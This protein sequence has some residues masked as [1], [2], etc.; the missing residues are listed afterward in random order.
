M[1]YE[2]KPSL[3]EISFDAHQNIVTQYEERAKSVGLHPDVRS[4]LYER[5]ISHRM[6]C[7]QASDMTQ[8]DRIKGRF[9]EIQSL[10]DLF[11]V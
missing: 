8:I 7:A 10:L 2:A 11:K 1:D 3:I 5:M 4:Y 6:D 9:L